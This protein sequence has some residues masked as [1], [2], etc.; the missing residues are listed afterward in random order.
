MY[1]FSHAMCKHF[2]F[3]LNWN[4]T[5]FS[6]RQIWDEKKNL[7]SF[8]IINIISKCLRWFQNYLKHY[9]F[10]SNILCLGTC[11]FVGSLNTIALI[12]FNYLYIHEL[13][14]TFGSGKMQSTNILSRK[15]WIGMLY[16]TG[17]AFSISILLRHCKIIQLIIVHSY[18][19]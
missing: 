2:V 13:F 17:N 5:Y 15:C 10:I 4:N 14:I 6:N 8:E 18:L 11:F 1:V 16:I 3:N 19:F 7:G 9:S 12:T